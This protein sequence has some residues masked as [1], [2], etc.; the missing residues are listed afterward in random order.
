MRETVPVPDEFHDAVVALTEDEFLG[1][2]G[3]WQPMTP[4]EIAE[5]LHGCEAGWHIAGGRAARAG[6][7]AERRHED[8]DVVVLARDLDAVRVAMRDWHLWENYNG[9]LRPLLPGVP[10]QTECHQVWVRRDARSPWRMEFLV[11]RASTEEEW[12]FKRDQSVR[13]PWN[14]ALRQIDGIWYLKPELALLFKAGQD[15]EKDR[16]DLAVAR[17]APEGR[18]WLTATLE[19]LGYAEWAKLA[20]QEG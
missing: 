19:K 17:L 8:T 14:Q 4:A 15:R 7:S 18:Q 13:V 12:V 10:D 6:A 9:A 11:D 16:E 20:R 1:R 5:M 2:Y 3:P